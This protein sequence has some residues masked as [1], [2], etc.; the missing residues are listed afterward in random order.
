[1]FVSTTLH[2]GIEDVLNPTFRLV[3]FAS[4]ADQLT[5]VRM[6]RNAWTVEEPK[7]EAGGVEAAF[8]K[9]MREN[10]NPGKK[11]GDASITKQNSDK[12]D[13]DTP[14]R[15]HVLFYYNHLFVDIGRM[16]PNVNS[17]LGHHHPPNHTSFSLSH[18]PSPASTT[19]TF[20]TPIIILPAFLD[21][22]TKVKISQVSDKDDSTIREYGVFDS[23][24]MEEAWWIGAGVKLRMDVVVDG[25]EEENKKEGVAAVFAVGPLCTERHGGED[26]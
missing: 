10:G 1:M 16:L 8:G 9:W 19:R 18:S 20:N 24:H 3:N 13:L 5:V 22:G 15:Q 2:N 6:L 23:K 25:T 14:W 12:D 4:S 26:D 11:W 7:M 21:Y 17:S